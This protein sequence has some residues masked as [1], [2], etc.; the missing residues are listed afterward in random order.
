MRNSPLIENSMNYSRKILKIKNC[1]A[2][3]GMRYHSSLFA[4]LANKPFIMIDYS[5]KC[6]AFANDIKLPKN[7]IISIN[8]ILKGRLGTYIEELLKNPHMFFA[9]IPPE[10]IKKRLVLFDE[11][12]LKALV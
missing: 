7:S 11:E 10:K 6:K 1:D 3:L 2:F 4:Y 12:I 5:S 8:D 9:Q